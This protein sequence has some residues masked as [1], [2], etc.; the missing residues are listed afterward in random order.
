MIDITT[1]LQ[2]TAEENECSILR[3]LLT[4]LEETIEKEED[5]E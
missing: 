1:R 3:A 2:N 4:L 5:D